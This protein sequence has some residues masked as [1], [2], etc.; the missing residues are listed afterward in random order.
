MTEFSRFWDSSGTGDGDAG[1]VT[2]AQWNEGWR[3]FAGQEATNL[4]AIFPDYLN[5]LA[6]TGSSTPVQIAAGA[7]NVYGFIYTNSAAVN[8]AVGTPSGDTRIDR[9]VLRANWSAQTVRI[10]LVAGSEGGAAPALTQSASTTWDVPICQVSITTGGAITLTDERGWLNLVGDG[11]ITLV[12]MAVNS[13]DSDQYVDGSIDTAHIAA[14]QITSALIADDQVDSEHLAA[15][16]VDLEHMSAN[17]VDSD[18]YVDAS[19]DTA[20]IA[21]DAINGTLIGDNVI[22]SEHYAAASIDNEH[23]ADDAVG[24]DELA[25]AAVDPRASIQGTNGIIVDPANGNSRGTDA[26]DLQTS[27]TVD[28]EVAAGTSSTIGGGHKNRAT[29][30]Y[31]TVGGGD[32]CR[33][34]GATSAT[35]GG[36][37]DNNAGSSFSV[38]PGGKEASADKYGQKTHASGMFS[39]Q[40]DAQTSVMVARI[41]TTNAT[42]AALFLD[43]SAETID[44]ATDTTWGFDIMVV[45]RRT[46]ADDESGFFKFEGC[47]DNNAGTTALVSSVVAASPIQDN[48]WV[49]TVTADDTND[50]LLI[51]VTGEGG[52]TINWVARVTTVEVTG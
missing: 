15:G 33:A 38:V 23:L 27:R 28:S 41:Q 10:T 52:K 8:V 13:I 46:D 22:D 14:D 2:E 12:K 36:G 42:P 18:Q 5:E 1:G 31:N 3:A 25:A 32:T 43:G 40:G 44:I 19:I 26:V 4:G 6:P 9:I 49:C 11:D 20:H 45:A 16:G 35:V 51:T 48:S 29:G 47:I 34:V 39:A 17:S 50:A 7:A 37:A 21:L 30:S 24:A